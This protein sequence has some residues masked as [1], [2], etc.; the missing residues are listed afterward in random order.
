MGWLKKVYREHIYGVMGALVFHI[1]LFSLFLLTD[2]DIKGKMKEEP[3]WI[4]FPE[5]VPEQE[6]AE[7]KAVEEESPESSSDRT[8]QRTN[9]PSRQGFPNEDDFFDEAYLEDI[10]EA[11]QLITE[12]NNQ[13]SQKVI[14]LEELA[15][16]V[17]NTEDMHPDSIRNVVYSGESNITYDLE[18]RYHVSL[19]IPVYLAYGGG[20][21][22]TDILVDRNGRVIK[23]E[24]RKNPSVTDPRT[25][26]YATLAAQRTIFN[27]DSS[28]PETQQGTITYH[29]VA[30]EM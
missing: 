16:P 29:F 13:L 25:F 14:Q 23:A 18:N 20:K 30:Q 8:E 3:V 15:M 7:K 28:A 1:L 5:I 4:D 6:I 26:Y 27:A 21:V 17:D 22:V 19:P 11:Q 2:I 24:A 12:V 9:R 10:R